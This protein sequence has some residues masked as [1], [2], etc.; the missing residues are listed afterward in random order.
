MRGC[1]ESIRLLCLH[2][3]D[4]AYGWPGEVTV[5]ALAEPLRTAKVAGNHSKIH[6]NDSPA[7]AWAVH[8]AAVTCVQ[9]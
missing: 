1:Q 2:L 9:G 5:P 7:A 3:T 4:P 6:R 8:E